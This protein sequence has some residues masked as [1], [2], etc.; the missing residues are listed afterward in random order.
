MCAQVLKG[1]L[2]KLLS[3][4]LFLA[5]TG[6]FPVISAH[7]H[8]LK[9][10]TINVWSGL[11]YNGF[12]KM[13]E[14]ESPAHKEKRFH[15]LVA[16]LRSLAPDVIFVQEANPVGS[17]AADL[18]STMAMVEI[19]QVVNG[20]VKIG[21]LGIPTNLKEGLVILAR[22]ELGLE[23]VDSWK[24]SGSKG[25]HSDLLTIHFDEAVLALVGRINIGGKNVFL[26]N[27][28]LLAAPAIPKDLKGFE[29]GV[30]ARGEMNKEAL[31]KALTLWKGR[32]QRRAKEVERLL[33]NLQRLPI[34]ASSIV[35]GDFNAEPDSAE[36]TAF[37][38]QGRFTEGT[39]VKGR[40]LIRRTDTF[41]WDPDLNEN[42]APSARTTDARRQVRKGFDYMAAT[43]N[44]RRRRLDYLFVNEGASEAGIV[45]NRVVLKQHINGVQASDHFGVLADVVF[46]R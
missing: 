28:H 11:D 24:L 46:E 6:A 10:L 18:A 32:H 37:R 5:A 12:V 3:V 43:A 23:K 20:G 40:G 7:G 45:E 38:V 34:G 4:L 8:P 36:M 2:K 44:N 35:G 9:I 29:R 39:I 33:D 27:V 21:P 17:Y 1:L 31:G 41:T 26:I 30:L 22:P 19:H 14:Y 25:V 42:V 15:S 13:G 16:Q